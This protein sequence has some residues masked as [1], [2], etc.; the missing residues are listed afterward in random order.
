MPC[1]DSSDFP[2]PPPPQDLFFP[3]CCEI[4]MISFLL[5]SGNFYSHSSA[6]RKDEAIEWWGLRKHHDP[7]VL[8]AFGGLGGF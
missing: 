5:E 2:L 4:K 6:H 8:D 1:F 3:H 7:R